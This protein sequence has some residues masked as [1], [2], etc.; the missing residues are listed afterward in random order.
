MRKKQLLRTGISILM[1]SAMMITSIPATGNAA[2]SD[3]ATL[4]E[5]AA[6]ENGEAGNLEE[7]YY[8]TVYSTTKDFYETAANLPQE[9]RSIYMAV[10]RDG[11]NYDVLNNGGGVIFAKEGSKQLNSPRVY[12]NSEGLFE[13]VAPDSTASNGY[14]TFTSKDGVAYYDETLDKSDMGDYDLAEPLNKEDVSLILKGE[15]ILETDTT[16]TL[17]N[18]WRLTKEEYTHIVNKLGTS[19]KYGLRVAGRRECGNGC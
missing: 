4:V 7:N 15:N 1:A 14:H 12:K 10:S 13:V 5:G 3:G 11:K 19:S 16:I 17:G 8:I 18:A 2:A 9:T 6:M